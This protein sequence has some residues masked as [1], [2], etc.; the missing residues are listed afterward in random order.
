MPQVKPGLAEA[1]SEL[2][3]AAPRGEVQIHPGRPLLKVGAIALGIVPLILVATVSGDAA[4]HAAGVFVFGVILLATA[5]FMRERTPWPYPSPIT[6]LVFYWFILYGPFTFN[7]FIDPTTVHRALVGSF[8]EF[9]QGMTLTILSAALIAA[10]YIAI[11][12]S[13]IIDLRSKALAGELSVV[14]AVALW[15]LSIVSRVIQFAN[16]Q[17]G[18][19]ATNLGQRGYS[20]QMILT[21]GGQMSLVVIAALFL[22]IVMDRKNVAPQVK[23]I[24]GLVL[25][26]EFIYAISVG[27]K[28][29]ILQTLVP[30]LLVMYGLRVKFPLKSIAAVFVILLFIAPGNYAYRDAVNDG[31]VK[32]GDMVNVVE[33]SVGLTFAM[34]GKGPVDA[35]EKTWK[36]ITHELADNLENVALILRKTPSQIPYWGSEEYRNIIP[37]TLFPRFLWKGKPSSENAGIITKVYREAESNSGSPTGFTGDLFMRMGMNGVIVGSFA[38]GALLAIHMRIFSR[39]RSKRALIVYATVIGTTVYTSELAPLLTMLVQRSLIFGVLSV[40][41]YHSDTW[42]EK[43]NPL[44]V[45][46][47]EPAHP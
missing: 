28:G 22:E 17:F 34:W 24:L 35:I 1:T 14:A 33:T 10:G 41:I 27:F 37:R 12:P 13:K 29:V 30:V 47:V 39:F 3:A 40:V 19:V 46:K 38:L 4:T 42:T 16:G 11:Y 2:P 45:Q 20:Y 7:K 26:A 25:T 8:R 43:L 15:G 23:L 9:H 5:R 32:K 6:T 18:Y 44:K 36:S 21:Y 31:K